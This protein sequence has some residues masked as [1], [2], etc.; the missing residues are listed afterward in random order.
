MMSGFIFP[1][2]KWDFEPL[3][4]GKREMLFNLGG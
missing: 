4:L 2:E 3:L 1:K